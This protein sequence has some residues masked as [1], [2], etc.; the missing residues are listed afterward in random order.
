MAGIR[1]EHATCVYP[2]SSAPALD[3]VDLRVIDG[4]LLVLFGPPRSGKTTALRVIAGLEDLAR[5][6]V[7]IG[8]RDVTRI[9]PKDRNVAMVF[10]NYALYPHLS[11]GENMGFSLKISGIDPPEVQRR[12]VEA[13]QILGLTAWLD[14]KPSELS[15]A[16][17]QQVSLARAVVRQPQVFLMDEPLAGLAPQLRDQTRQ[18]IITLQKQLGI[19]TVYAT[20]DQV[21]AMIMADR[22]AFIDDG[23]LAQVG[24]PRELYD[25]PA[26]LR[27]ARAIGLPP[28]NL[29]PRTVTDSRVELGPWSREVEGVDSVIV[30]VRPED[31]VVAGQGLPGIV[32]ERVETSSGDYLRVQCG[33]VEPDSGSLLARVAG[34]P[35]PGVGEQV[36]L[37]PDADHIHVFT[38]DGRRL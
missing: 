26:D 22:V 2:G 16:Q 19:T 6:Q 8:E 15:S 7:F 34:S 31:L 11:V 35:S 20:A 32:R 18:Q 9:E 17:R 27:V 1:F 12:V 25:W 30:G 5:G 36:R 24:T 3:G 28:M 4:E 10:Q 37:R 14:A 23:R 13:A 29:I 33:G 38:Q 21:E